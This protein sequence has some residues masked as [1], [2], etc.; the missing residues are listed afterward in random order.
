MVAL[1]LILATD[2]LLGLALSRSG[3]GEG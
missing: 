2:R 3:R 1:V